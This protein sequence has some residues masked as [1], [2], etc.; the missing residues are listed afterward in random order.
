[1]VAVVQKT[2]SLCLLFI[3][4]VQT[5]AVVAAFNTRDGTQAEEVSRM[6]LGG[7]CV[8]QMVNGCFSSSRKLS[9]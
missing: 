5:W 6:T 7:E 8:N 2:M 3:P 4:P 9:F 1:M